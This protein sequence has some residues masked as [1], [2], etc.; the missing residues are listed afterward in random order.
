MSGRRRVPCWFR[1][2]VS[3]SGRMLSADEPRCAC[4][5]RVRPVTRCSLQLRCFFFFRVGRSGGR[6]RVIISACCLH[7]NRVSISSS[8]SVLRLPLAPLK[9]AP[10][11]L[12]WPCRPRSRCGF[13]ARQ[14]PRYAQRSCLRSTCHSSR[15]DEQKRGAVSLCS[16]N[17][18]CFRQPSTCAQARTMQLT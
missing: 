1:V 9:A 13:T 16:P 6:M 18:G 11:A 12:A 5:L 3:L 8:V 17:E 7:R 4:Y 15:C 14:Q 10:V 2:F